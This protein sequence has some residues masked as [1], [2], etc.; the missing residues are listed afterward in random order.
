MKQDRLYLAA[1]GAVSGKSRSR[2]R[3]LPHTMSDPSST[4]L[5]EVQQQLI[6]GS[7]TAG[8]LRFGSFTLKSGRC[9]NHCSALGLWR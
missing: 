3:S 4:P 1:S 2:Y 6:D 7:F 8:A 5:S 9:D